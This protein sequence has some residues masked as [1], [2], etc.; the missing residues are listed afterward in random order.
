MVFATTL[1]G[2]NPVEL[3][4]SRPEQGDNLRYVR[5]SGPTSEVA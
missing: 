3:V 2:T 4:D 1:P 5:G